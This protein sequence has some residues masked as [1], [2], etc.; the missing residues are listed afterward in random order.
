M[1]KVETGFLS[2][3]KELEAMAKKITSPVVRKRALE[4]GAKPIADE[5]QRLI[6]AK[7][8]KRSG[9][10]SEGVAYEADDKKAKI[11]W[12]KEAFYGIYHEV[13]TSKM[14]ARPHMR[15]A[16]QSKKDE[17]AKAMIKVYQEEI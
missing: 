16:Y 7:T 6:I 11:G 14:A 9:R 10:L 2:L 13:G 15:P 5:A 12:T 8:K 4:A 17:A 1:S 3:G